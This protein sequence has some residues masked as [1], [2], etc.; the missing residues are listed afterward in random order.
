MVDWWEASANGQ[1]PS[2]DY[3]C[4]TVSPPHE[5]T[6]QPSE[7]HVKAA[8]NPIDGVELPCR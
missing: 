8:V 3:L 5:S 1:S 4:E 2:M 7:Q 6:L